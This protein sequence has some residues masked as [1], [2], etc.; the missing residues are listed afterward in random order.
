MGGEGVYKLLVTYP[1]RFAGGVAV[2]AY[3]LDTGADLM[4]ETPLWI[5]HGSE[6]TISGVSNARDIYQSILDVGGSQVFYTEYEGLDH[7]PSISQA[8]SEP[9]LLEWL[10]EQ[11]RKSGGRS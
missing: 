8:S 9:G 1:D 5:F 4:A 10:L 7:N 2:A 3:T 11:S 6:D